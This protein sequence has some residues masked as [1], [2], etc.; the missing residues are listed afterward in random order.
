MIELSVIRDLVAIFGVIAGLSY[1]ILTVR[2]ANKAR[3]KDVL[4]QRINTVDDDFYSKWRTY[5]LGG[6]NTYEEWLKYDEEHPEAY[7]FISYA[8][9][10]LNSIGALL[11]DNMVDADSLFS[12]YSPIIIIWTWER[13]KIITDFYREHINLPSYLENFEYLYHEAKRRF[14]EMVSREDW[15]V[16]HNEYKKRIQ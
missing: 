1:Y 15:N 6:I 9:Q 11:K 14:P 5:A 8:S 12:V 4:L 7:G 2:N 16:L 3:W 10:M 13:Y